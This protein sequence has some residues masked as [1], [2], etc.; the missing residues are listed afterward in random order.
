MQHHHYVVHLHDE[1]PPPTGDTMYTVELEESSSD[2][3]TESVTE[4]LE[5]VKT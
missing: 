3:T 5:E 1:Q 2:E 4:L